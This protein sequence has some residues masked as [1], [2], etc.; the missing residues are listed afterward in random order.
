VIAGAALLAG[1]YSYTPLATPAPAVGMRL[2]LVL[3]DQGRYEAARQV[4]PSIMRVEGALIQSSD[5]EYLLQVT[6]VVDV[7]GVRSRWAGETVP[8]QR[9]YVAATYERRFSRGRTAF[10][11]VGVAS[12]FVALVV[13]RNLLGFAGGGNDEPPGGPPPDQL[14]TRR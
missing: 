3:N 13:G 14:R 10:F 9:A 1:C 8:L 12:A 7:A 11:V 5:A 6:D 4:G 2:A